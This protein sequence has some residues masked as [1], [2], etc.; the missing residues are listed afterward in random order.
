[1]TGVSKAAAI[2]QLAAEVGLER[3]LV[4]RDPV[5]EGKRRASAVAERDLLV[6]WCAGRGW[7]PWVIDQLELSLVVDRFGRRRVRFPFRLA[8]HGTPYWQDRAL[9]GAAR[10]KWL[11]PPGARP[12]LYE[13]DR[14]RLAYERG[15]VLVVEGV[16][17]VAALVDVYAG[18][19][20]VGVPGA[21]AWRS[22]WMQVFA[23]LEV[24]IVT[25]NHRAGTDLRARLDRDLRPMARTLS[26]V[27]VPEEHGDVADWR[28]SLD[29]EAFDSALMAAVDASGHRSGLAAL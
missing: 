3:R 4:K 11:S 12:I 5:A 1:L 18:P 16:S 22:K 27:R 15:A 19:A 29:P 13:A 6:R 2:D 23:G 24:F 25:D 9:D 21:S 28:A 26:H 14:L 20:V 10:V 8:G 7:G 17:D